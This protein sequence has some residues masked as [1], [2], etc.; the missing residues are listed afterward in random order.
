VDDKDAPTNL[1]LVVYSAKVWMLKDLNKCM[2]TSAMLKELK[3]M[4]ELKECIFVTTLTWLKSGQNMNKRGGHGQNNSRNIEMKMNK[5]RGLRNK[6]VLS[7][8]VL[9]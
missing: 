4:V 2:L 5:I 1:D 8:L 3:E 6:K 9:F 7:L